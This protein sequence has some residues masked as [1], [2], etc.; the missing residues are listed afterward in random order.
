M[1]NLKAYISAFD[2]PH[3]YDNSVNYKWMAGFRNGLIHRIQ[4]N[5]PDWLK[6]III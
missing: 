2:S 5:I 4:P 1:N 6:M 3:I